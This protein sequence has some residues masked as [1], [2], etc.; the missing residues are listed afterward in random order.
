MPDPLRE[1]RSSAPELRRIAAEAALAGAVVAALFAVLVAAIDNVHLVTTNGLWKSIK[2]ATFVEAPGRSASPSNLLYYP[3]TGILTW[4]LPDSAFGAVWRKMAFLNAAWSGLA[5]AAT[6]AVVRVLG[7]GRLGATSAAL[8]Q[9]GCGF[10]LALGITNEDIMGGYALLVSSVACAT[11]GLHRP[12]RG[13]TVA[14]ALA[15]ILFVACWFWEWRLLFPI[16]PAYAVALAAAAAPLR[17]RVRRALLFVGISGSLVVAAAI[18][19]HLFDDRHSV[20]GWILGLIWTGKGVGTGW[21]GFAA[22]KWLFLWIGMTQYWVGGLNVGVLEWLSHGWNGA[23][24]ALVLAA[25]AGL[26]AFLLVSGLR[27]LGDPAWRTFGFLAGGTFLGGQVMN[28]YSQPQDP[29]MQLNPMFWLPIAWGLAVA[30]LARRTRSR[31][32]AVLALAASAA[33]LPGNLFVSDAFWIRR[34]GDSQMLQ[35]VRAFETKGELERSL[36]VFNGFDGILSWVAVEVDWEYPPTLATS[37]QAS[38]RFKGLFLLEQATEYP[39]LSAD[40]SAALVA[41]RLA[42][43]EGR[44][45]RIVIHDLWEWPVETFVDS[46]STVSGPEKPTAIHRMLHE[47]YEGTKIFEVDGLGRFYELRRKEETGT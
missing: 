24:T 37:P 28:L 13:G 5:V 27:R 38:P 41:E 6:F 30:A 32:F 40:E 35:Q 26:A 4:I 7:A 21:G 16:A 25:E 17:H 45:F 12:G 43:A 3:V 33:W 9:A 23:R 10:F 1:S 19:A 2:V 44:G 31:T 11:W 29:Q 47:R 14:T 39:R 34:G 36:Y 8:F 15:A 18:V 46:F 20:G 22:R 42:D